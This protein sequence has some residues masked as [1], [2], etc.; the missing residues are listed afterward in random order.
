MS[1]EVPDLK[2]G[3]GKQVLVPVELGNNL[4]PRHRLEGLLWDVTANP[5]HF[6]DV[7]FGVVSAGDVRLTRVVQSLQI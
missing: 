4:L 5:I 2:L 1:M 7:S 3:R 6:G